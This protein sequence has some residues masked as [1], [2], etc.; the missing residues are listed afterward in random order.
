MNRRRDPYQVVVDRSCALVEAHALGRSILRHQRIPFEPRRGS[1]AIDLAIEIAPRSL[2][3]YEL[4][5]EPL[6]AVVLVGACRVETGGREK[7]R[8]LEARGVRAWKGDL[9]AVVRGAL[10]DQRLRREQRVDRELDP[11]ASANQVLLEQ[12]VVDVMP[13]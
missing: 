4:I 9:D 5:D 12:R 11:A 2:P 13:G 6:H 7:D 8:L 1:G 10:G 3:A